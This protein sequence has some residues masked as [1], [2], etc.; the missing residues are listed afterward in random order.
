[1]NKFE[2]E[3]IACT[4]FED[5]F[6]QTPP[7][8]R[9]RKW[10]SLKIKTRNYVYSAVAW[11]FQKGPSRLSESETIEVNECTDKIIQK[12]DYLVLMNI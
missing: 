8:Q 9:S 4:F 10:L 12:I 11:H 6:S 7:R 2:I 3:N 1:M 5:I